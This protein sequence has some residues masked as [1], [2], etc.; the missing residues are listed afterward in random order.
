VVQQLL[1]M[2]ALPVVAVV[3]AVEQMLPGLLADATGLHRTLV[4]TMGACKGVEK[5]FEL[6][7]GL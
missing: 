4:G 3:R 1:E 7:L 2:A 6:L 5:Q